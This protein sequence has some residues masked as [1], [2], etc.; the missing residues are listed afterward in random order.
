MP[1]KPAC[2]LAMEALHVMLE[3]LRRPTSSLA[4]RSTVWMWTPSAEALMDPMS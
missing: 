1:E 3:I 4:S 2:I